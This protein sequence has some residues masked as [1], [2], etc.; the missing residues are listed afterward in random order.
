MEIKKRAVCGSLSSNDVLVTVEP[1]D[2]LQIEIESTVL[3][4]FGD[5][6]RQ[7][8]LDTACRMGVTSGFIHLEDKGAL[9][10]TIRARVETAIRRS[11]E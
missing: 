5:Q 1:S 11:N 9:D 7:V 8:T 6:I 3:Y 2:R 4:E 10:C